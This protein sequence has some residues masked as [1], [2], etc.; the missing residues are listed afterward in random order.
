M[1]T[2]M[3]RRLTNR[4]F[5]IIIII[6]KLSRVLRYY[7]DRKIVSKVPGQRYAYRLMNDDDD[8]DE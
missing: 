5:I 7:Y 4:R 3:L 8:D 6:I 1:S 2:D